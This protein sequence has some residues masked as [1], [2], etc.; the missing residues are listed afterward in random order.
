M[1]ANQ[2]MFLQPSARLQ[3]FLG[4]ELIADPNLA[5]LEFVKNAYDAGASDVQVEFEISTQPT[6]LVI[7]DNGIGM[8][9]RSFRANWLRPGFSSKSS[10]YDGPDLRS[11]EN[12]EAL[13]RSDSRSPA[14]EK[15]LGRLAAGRLGD[16]LTVFT[17]THPGSPWLRV[18]FVWSDFDDMTK[19]FNEVAIPFDYVDE[20]PAGAYSVGTIIQIENLN[21]VWIGK[22]P[23]RPAPGRPRTRLGR[24][25]QDLA[26]L[27]RAEVDKARDFNILLNSDAVTDPNDIGVIDVES[28]P[29]E[30]AAYVYEFEVTSEPVEGGAGAFVAR[31]SSSIAR[32]AEAALAASRPMAE[33]LPDE[34]FESLSAA[35]DPRSRMGSAGSFR[36]MFLYTPPQAAKRAKNVEAASAGVLLYRDDVLVEPYGLPGDDWVGVE[37]RKASRQGHAAIQPATFAGEVRITRELNSGLVDMSN[38]LGLLENEASSDFLA[39]VRAE[40]LKFEGIILLEVLEERWADNREDKA[41]ERAAEVQTFARA[42]LRAMAHRAGQPLQSM[43]IE[44]VNIRTVAGRTGLDPLVVAQLEGIATSLETSVKRL[45]GIVSSLT[46]VLNLETTSVPLIELVGE[47]VDDVRGFAR[48][49]GVEIDVDVTDDLTVLVPEGLIFEALTELVVNAI[50][51]PRK[52]AQGLVRI[53]TRESHSGIEIDV[54]DDG[55]GIPG[56]PDQPLD[57]DQLQSTKGRPAGGLLN[58]ESLVVAGRGSLRIVQSTESGTTVRVTMPRGVRPK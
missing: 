2:R 25:K 10:D 17:R 36:G 7:S 18:R 6:S 51:A 57:L 35:R 31:I 16:V 12:H 56:V 33:S 21:Q 37:A 15:G 54:V 50:E 24:L 8:D 52:S 34:T 20:A 13:K 23:G 38:R 43:G 26:F 30:T 4:R 46:T 45:S 3:R 41:S 49:S 48:Q 40:F 47:V 11:A 29:L 5:V 19:S 14:G 53:V 32:S 42:R 44:A 28:S 27:I 39:L 55:T 58:A 9:E 1:S 22:V